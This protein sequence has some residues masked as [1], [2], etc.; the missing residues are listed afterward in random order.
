MGM[1]GFDTSPVQYKLTE[2]PYTENSIL[3]RR[4]ESHSREHG[5]WAPGSVIEIQA[6]LLEEWIGG[7]SFLKF[8]NTGERGKHSHI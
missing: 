3:Y 7:I 8:S 6:Y 2:Y 4:V 1:D 5:G